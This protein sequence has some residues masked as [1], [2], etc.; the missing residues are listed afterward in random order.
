[1]PR[2]N[3]KPFQIQTP[4]PIFLTTSC[5]HCYLLHVLLSHAFRIVSLK[6]LLPCSNLH[7]SPPKIL[8]R[9]FSVLNQSPSWQSFATGLDLHRIQTPEQLI[10]ARDCCKRLP[11]GIRILSHVR[12]LKRSRQRRGQ[13]FKCRPRPTVCS[14]VGNLNPHGRGTKFSVGVQPTI[15]S[16]YRPSQ[17]RML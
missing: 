15:Q 1:M 6:C 13:S 7:L 10:S 16:G 2:I 14:N 11:L 5:T 12:S 4:A 9:N 8:R 17:R 3:R